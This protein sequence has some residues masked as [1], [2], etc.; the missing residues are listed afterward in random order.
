MICSPE[1][2]SLSPPKPASSLPIVIS[3]EFAGSGKKGIDIVRQCLST[4]NQ[5]FCAIGVD[6]SY[7]EKIFRIG[8]NET[9]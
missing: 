2:V 6:L 9:D 7:S 3:T 1:E 4:Q 5:E 8:E